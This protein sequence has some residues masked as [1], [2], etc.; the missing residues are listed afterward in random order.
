MPNKRVLIIDDDPNICEVVK[1]VLEFDNIEV[2][3][4]ATPEEGLFEARYK[5]PDIILLDLFLPNMS[6][7]DVYKS[8]KNDDRT[9]DIPV[10]IITG[11]TDASTV[12]YAQE[13]GLK[14]VFYKPFNFG[15]LRKK[16]K[17][18]TDDID[19]R[20]SKCPHCGR[21]LEDSWQ[22]CP[23]DGL[24]RNSKTRK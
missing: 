20:Q 13:L 4:A 15:Q 14:G 6:G 18:L 7:F 5:S 23:Y 11:H 19:D 9:K 16:I 3:K 8:L 1:E 17:Y 22:F 21:E 2:L 10:I 12:T 24:N